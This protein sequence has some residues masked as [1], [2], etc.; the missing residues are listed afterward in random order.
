MKSKIHV[1]QLQVNSMSKALF[2]LT[3][4]SIFLTVFS[5]KNE[6]QTVN[7]DYKFSE[8]ENVLNCINLDTKLFNEALLSFED[9]IMK[10]YNTRNSDVRV[11]YTTFFRATQ[12]N[13]VNYQ[14]LVSP[15]TMEVFEALKSHSDLWTDNNQLNY[16]AEIFNCIGNNMQDKGLATTY[17]SLIST[18]SMRADLFGA[19]LQQKIKTANT[20]RYLATFMALDLF[21]AK[22]FKVDPTQVTEKKVQEKTTYRTEPGKPMIKQKTLSET[23]EIEDAHAGHNHD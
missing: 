18:N 23:K 7:L 3:V 15:H 14:E 19:P 1:N 9:D 2:K 4:V 13:G 10:T 8:T 6:T 12:R 20:D 16:N 21:Y 17:K 11:A 5:C 22:L